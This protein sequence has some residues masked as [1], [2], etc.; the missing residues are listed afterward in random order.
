MRSYG[1]FLW[2]FSFLSH[3]AA[4]S[5]PFSTVTDPHWDPSNSSQWGLFAGCA[6]SWNEIADGDFYIGSTL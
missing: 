1:L 4:Q 5:A 6:V 2:P 3:A